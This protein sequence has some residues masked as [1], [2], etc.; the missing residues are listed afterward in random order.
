MQKH[1]SKLVVVIIVALL[2]GAGIYYEN[3]HSVAKQITEDSI[4]IVE[5]PSGEI[6]KADIADT[7]SKRNAGLSN[8]EQ[9]GIDEGLLF[10][11]DEK[12]IHNYWMKDMLFA[13]DIIWID[14]DIVTGFSENLLPENP[15]STIYSPEVPVDYVLEVQAGFVDEIGL[16]KGD[17]LDI[18]L[19]EQ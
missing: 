1:K 16:L 5:F 17:K 10:L 7:E 4:A 8:R 2:L 9:I 6:I 12:A 13:I 11:H 19:P 3:R 18:Q 14:G 15:A